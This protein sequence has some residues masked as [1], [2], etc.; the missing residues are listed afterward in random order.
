MCARAELKCSVMT[1]KK[2]SHQSAKDKSSARSRA[3]RVLRVRVWNRSSILSKSKNQ[4][5]QTVLVCAARKFVRVRIS[6]C[7]DRKFVRRTLGASVHPDFSERRTNLL[8]SP[9]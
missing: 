1:K 3:L 2:Q 5:A 6:G 4:G 8:L 7:T 9:N